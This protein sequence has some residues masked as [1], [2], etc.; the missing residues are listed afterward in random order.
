GPERPA[1]RVGPYGTTIAL[2]DRTLFGPERPLTQLIDENRLPLIKGKLKNASLLVNKAQRR[3]ELWVRRKMV[4]AYR[5]QL[6]LNAHG[7]KVRQGDRRT[8]EG[9]YFICDHRP[10]TYCLGLWLAYPNAADARRGLGSRLIGAEEYGA[11]AGRLAKGGCP[12]QNTKLG[13]DI[14]IHGQLP[15]LTR[16]LARGHRADPRTLRPGYRVGDADPDAQREFQDWTNG[17]VALFNPDIR[18]LYE[19]IPDGAEVIIVANAPVTAPR[20]ARSDTPTGSS[21]RYSDAFLGTP[22][23]RILLGSCPVCREIF[24]SGRICSRFPPPVRRAFLRPSNVPSGWYLGM[25][26]GLLVASRTRRDSRPDDGQNYRGLN[27]PPN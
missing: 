18:E 11:I 17:C 2:Y 20:K 23:E 15:D 5:I 25:F 12:P 22:F 16:Q 24:L 9:T 19:F 4:K 6:G 27:L 13:G 21:R 8:P 7:P 14:L 1:E 10:S 26:F 3:L